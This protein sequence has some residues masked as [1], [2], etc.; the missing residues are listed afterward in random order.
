M[1]LLHTSDWHVGK[2]IRGHSRHDEHVAVLDEIVQIAR[3]K[4]VDVVLVAGDLFETASPTPDAEALV[5]RTLLA[6]AQDST[7]VA[8]IAGNHDNARRLAAV[9]PLLELGNVHLTTEPRGPHA[10]GVLDLD[11][12]GERLSLAMLPFVSQ[13]GII[14]STDLMDGAAFEHANAYADRMR[15][16]VDLLTRDFDERSVNVVIGHAFVHGGSIGG[17]ERLAH[18]VEEYAITAQSFPATASYVA[19]GHLHRPQKIAGPCPIHYSGSPIQLDFGESGEPNQVNIIDVAAGTPAAVSAIPLTAG[20]PL[21]TMT[22]TLDD[23]RARAGELDVGGQ[24]PWI[25]VRVDEP[26][27]NDLADDV[28][29]LLGDRVVDVQLVG[30]TEATA[31]KQAPRHGRDPFTLF[32]EYLEELGIDDGDVRSLFVELLEDQLEGSN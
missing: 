21:V 20:S 4:S 30:S 2:K 17:G 1:R 22:G 16:L 9:S 27:R 12:N 25:R 29:N 10:G 5:Y 11:M 14:R 6:L 15:T 19:L 8:V 13:R 23:L 32:T 31:P 18:L 28:R 24:A 26:R 7:H 3:S